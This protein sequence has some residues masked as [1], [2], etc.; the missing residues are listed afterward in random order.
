MGPYTGT[1]HGNAARFDAVAYATL[2]SEYS[3]AVRCFTPPK[4]IITIITGLSSM[5]QSPHLKQLIATPIT[6]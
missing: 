4:V 1:I 6:P 5:R 2:P 3:A